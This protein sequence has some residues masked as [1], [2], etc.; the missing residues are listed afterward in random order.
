M[1]KPGPDR[2]ATDEKILAAIRDAYPPIQGTSDIADTLGVKRQ[3]ADK[4]LRSLEEQGMV[5]SELVGTV[6]V[7][8]LSDKGRRWLA[9]QG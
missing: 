5:E 8:W 2:Q 3:T 1:G 9:D 7:W 4:H 6:R